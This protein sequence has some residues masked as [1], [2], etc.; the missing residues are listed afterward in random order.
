MSHSLLKFSV[1]DSLVTFAILRISS[2]ILDGAFFKNTSFLLSQFG[3]EFPRSL[4]PTP[5]VHLL[6]I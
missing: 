4:S 1:Y 5:V 3:A 2:G 6:N